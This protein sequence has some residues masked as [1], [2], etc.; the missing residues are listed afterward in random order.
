[1]KA[2]SLWQPWATL[3]AIGAKEF[4]TRHWAAPKRLIGQRIAVHAA[5]RTSELHIATTYPFQPQLAAAGEHPDQLP[6]G[7]IVAT[8]V[9][10]DCW[11]MTQDLIDAAGE[12]EQA[13]GHWELGRYAWRMTDV[14][15]LAVPI[16]ARGAQGVWDVPFELA[17][18]LHA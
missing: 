2:L 9:V 7:A 5:K 12:I 15:Q 14:V 17:G 6:L 10:A 13:F 1:M 11:Q 3:I 18:Q 16:A 4:E 8:A